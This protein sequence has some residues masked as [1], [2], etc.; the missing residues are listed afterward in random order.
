MTKIHYKNS[1]LTEEQLKKVQEHYNAKFIFESCLKSISSGWC[2]FPAAIFYTE[3]AHPEGSNYLAFYYN[4]DGYPMVANGISATEPFDG[5]DTGDGI[6][7][8]RYRH[9]FVTHNDCMIDGGR[10]YTKHSLNGKIVKLG[11]DK[12]Q[13]VVISPSG[14]YG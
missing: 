9:D 7:Y 2:N 1:M 5:L 3:K 6:I 12:D 4:V 14:I 11:V 8:S 13:L 10:D